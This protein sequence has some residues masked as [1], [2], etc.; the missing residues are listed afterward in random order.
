MNEPSSRSTS[1]SGSDSSRS[2][3]ARRDHL[4]QAQVGLQP[5]DVG[6]VAPLRLDA[7]HELADRAL[8]D[9]VLAERGQDV[10]DVLHERA[11]RPDHEHAAVLQL[12]ALRV[13]QPRGA[14]QAD[15]GLAGARA[16]LDHERRVGLVGDQPVLVGL[17]RRDDVAHVH[18][19]VALELLE[20]EVADRG[21]V[22]D[23]AVERLVGDVEQ[24]AARRCGSA[25]AA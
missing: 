8:L 2:S 7:V 13:E 24:R 1:S 23:R 12:V 3:A 17:D 16:A 21:A 20:Q 25:G 4:D 22:D 5:R 18:V 9:G 10:R 19:A 6:R 15:R 14:V 11:V